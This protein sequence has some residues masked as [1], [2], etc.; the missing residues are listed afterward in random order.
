MPVEHP[1]TTT[2]GVECMIKSDVELDFDNTILY[3][4]R[5]DYG[6]Q[7]CSRLMSMRIFEI[8]DFVDRL[9]V[10]CLTCSR[11]RIILRKPVKRSNE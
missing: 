1:V 5:G 2:T 6:A 3:S 7:Q 9:W 8:S 4:K 10:F 11:F